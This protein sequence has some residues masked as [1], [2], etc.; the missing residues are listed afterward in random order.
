MCRSISPLVALLFLCLQ[1]GAYAAPCSPDNVTHMKYAEAF[2]KDYRAWVKQ[3]DPAS[4]KIALKNLEH[5]ITLAKMDNIL[6]CNAPLKARFFMSTYYIID[7]HMIDSTINAAAALMETGAPSPNP[8]PNGESSADTIIK[9]VLMQ[10][11]R[12]LSSA[13]QFG[14][15]QLFPAEYNEASDSVRSALRNIKAS[16]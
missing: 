15:L 1:S 4:S 14:A 7:G 10:E 13:K 3:D 2:S 5:Q 11:S 16:K 9:R 6:N 8:S 12:A